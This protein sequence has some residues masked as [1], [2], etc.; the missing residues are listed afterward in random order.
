MIIDFVKD[1]KTYLRCS[2]CLK[3]EMIL[4]YAIGGHYPYWYDYID[5]D[6]TVEGIESFK[7]KHSLCKMDCEQLTFL[8]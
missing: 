1:G 6:K 8:E 2:E 5:V 7:T 3:E 4:K